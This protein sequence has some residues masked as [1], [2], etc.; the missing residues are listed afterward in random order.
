MGRDVFIFRTWDGSEFCGVNGGKDDQ[1]NTI[2]HHWLTVQPW[3]PE[4]NIYRQKMP[5]LL[6]ETERL[7][8]VL[9]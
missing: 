3:G 7:N 8:Q 5:T 6:T 2:G 9:G 1:I 4:V